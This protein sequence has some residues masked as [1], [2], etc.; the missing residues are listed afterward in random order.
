MRAAII[1]DKSGRRMRPRSPR[2][3]TQLVSDFHS[4]Y[5]V[6]ACDGCWIWNLC[7]NSVGYGKFGVNGLSTYAHRFSWKI[8][9][10]E[11]PRNLFVLHKCDNRDCV[12][13]DHLFLGT[14]LD[15]M[16]DMIAKGRQSHP[17]GSDHFRAK[18]TEED[19]IELLKMDATGEYTY[20]DLASKFKISRSQI[21]NILHGVTWKAITRITRGT[22]LA[23]HKQKKLTKEQIELAFQLK[24]SKSQASIA[25]ILNCFPS[26]ISRLFSGQ[27]YKSA[28]PTPS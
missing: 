3:R 17:S 1:V 9:R 16:R 21:W 15:N 2:T 26:T 20:N 18:L 8:H 12:N 10:G 19:V 22:P 6:R 27:N 11:I 25:V 14:P 23:H 5:T 28:C 7:L 24:T 4:N 13:P